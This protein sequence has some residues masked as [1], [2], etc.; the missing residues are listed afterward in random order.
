MNVGFYLT[1]K[2]GHGYVFAAYLVD[3]IRRVLPYVSIHHFT[4]LKSPA[5]WSVDAVH[6]LPPQ[7]LCLARAEHYGSVIGDWLFLDTDTVVE[8]SLVSAIFEQDFSVAVTDRNW[9][10]ILYPHDS[11][12]PY[13]SG[14]IFSRSQSFWRDML[15][16]ESKMS[17]DL[18][19][20]YAEQRALPLVLPSYSHVVL[21]GSI[22]QHPPDDH[23]PP[24]SCAIS[25]YKGDRKRHLLRRIQ[26][27]LRLAV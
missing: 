8:S 11:D 14:V 15:D 5:L 24:S 20:W 26:R 13:C 9:P 16:V 2:D 4:D 1:S 25:H 18:Q 10:N 21:P 22:F 7:P 27:D 12:M 19:S 23:D 17:A 3:S 6:R